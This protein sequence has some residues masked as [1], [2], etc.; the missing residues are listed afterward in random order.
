MKETR[1]EVT[2][3]RQV[4]NSSMPAGN[5]QEKWVPVRPGSQD[6]EEIPSRMGQRTWRDGRVEVQS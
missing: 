5:H 1:L 2:P 6:H 3:P 4:T